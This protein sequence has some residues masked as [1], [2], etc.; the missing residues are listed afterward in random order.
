MSIDFFSHK[1]ILTAGIQTINNDLHRRQQGVGSTGSDYDLSLSKPGWGRDLHFIT[2]NVAVFMENKWALTERFSIN[3]SARMEVGK[4]RLEGVISNYPNEELPNT[5]E[6][7]FPL[8]G[9]S[10]QYSFYTK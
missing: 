6:H 8:L 4:S 5:I 1:N 2:N 7:K 10:L 3:T 9:T